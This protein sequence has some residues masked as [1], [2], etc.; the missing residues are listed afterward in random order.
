M[1]PPFFV[2]SLA[3]L[4][5]L[6]TVA[7]GLAGCGASSAPASEA[8]VESFHLVHRG[9]ELA[10]EKVTVTASQHGTDDVELYFLGSSGCGGTQIDGCMFYSVTLD[11]DP[12]ALRAGTPLTIDGTTT[13]TRDSR[14]VVSFSLAPTGNS[15]PAVKNVGAQ[16]GCD[17]CD[18]PPAKGQ[19]VAGQLALSSASSA[20]MAGSLHLT[21][22][23]TDA[24]GA[25][26]TETVD[27]VF[28][29]A[30]KQAP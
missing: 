29:V 14:G 12:N 25:A 30:V 18:P 2:T 26:S 20:S 17:P 13:Y 23:G 19:T 16:Q 1:R 15:S 6:L 28:E 10:F 9:K 11:L 5:S 3:S 21:L 4:A 22:T 24:L 7:S 8:G 27:A